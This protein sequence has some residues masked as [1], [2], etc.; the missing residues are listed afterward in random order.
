M[1]RGEGKRFEGSW[2]EGI[3][4]PREIYLNGVETLTILEV[5][6]VVLLL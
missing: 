3:L 1:R 2:G 6:E 5:F 4:I